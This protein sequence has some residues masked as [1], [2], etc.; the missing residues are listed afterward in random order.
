MHRW[1]VAR[2][3]TCADIFPIEMPFMA[4]KNSWDRLSQ[5]A[6]PRL[7]IDYFSENGSVI[8]VIRTRINYDH[9]HN[10]L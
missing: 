5:E 6:K 1:F 9:T 4:N 3:S 2:R 10:Y 7:S 8:I